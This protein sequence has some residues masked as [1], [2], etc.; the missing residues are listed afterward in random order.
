LQTPAT[1]AE[2]DAV[3]GARWWY[4]FTEAVNRS[5]NKANLRCRTGSGG[6]DRVLTICGTMRGAWY[7]ALREDCGA[8]PCVI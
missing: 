7:N 2:I 8:C 3:M 5:G 6:A 4:S 1:V